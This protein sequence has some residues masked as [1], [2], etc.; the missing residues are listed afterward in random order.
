[1]TTSLQV[2]VTYKQILK[3]ALPISL[4]LLVPQ[5]NF[6]IN[7]V[8]LGH[9][10]EQALATAS[11][12]G[13]YYLIFVGIGYGLNNGMQTLISR[14][15]GENKRE[16]IGKIFNQGVLI[17]MGIAAIGIGLTYFVA[18]LLLRYSIHSG[19]MYNDAINF[20]RIRI[21]GLPF[22]FVYQM[23]N[24]LL[25][26]INQSRYLVAGTLAEAVSNVVLDY[27]LI[28]GKLGMP[29]MGFTGAAVASI[30]S[31]FLGMFVIFLVIKW[32]GISKQFSIFKKMSWDTVN[33][34]L[35]ISI[36][37]PLIF[38]HGISLI[39]WTFFYILIEHHGQQSLAISTTMRNIFGFFGVFIWA[40]ASTTNSMVSNIIGQDKKEAVVPLIKKII[41][42]NVSVAVIICLTLNLFPSLFFSIYGQTEN[43][44]Q[45][46]L[47]VLRVVTFAMIL[48]S[49]S[50]VW[51]S[52]VSG[53]GNTKI[54]FVIEVIAIIVYS[55]YVYLVLE[56]YKLSIV[57]GWL[58]E[59][60]YWSILLILSYGYIKSNKW[61]LKVM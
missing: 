2:D 15:A 26:G 41:S 48:M 21:W 33:A 42:V 22:L 37:G 4:A 7:N 58:S 36:S 6:V 55:I 52:A 56:L 20:L 39:S 61:K 51:L 1:M 49:V 45:A 25:V 23:R 14:R 44:V 5:F 13:V 34:R 29:Q 19:Q 47:P 53:T 3:I 24:A 50:T 32:K 28:F 30:I 9:L 35:I 12:T 11:I 18:P 17:A 57:W 54:T 46:A 43:F 8:F 16:E 31:E 60:L 27:A 40:F 38:Q 59:V 10:S